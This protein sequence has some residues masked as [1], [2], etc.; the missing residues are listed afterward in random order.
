MKHITRAV[1]VSMLSAAAATVSAQ[2]KLGSATPEDALRP[3]WVFTPS[4]GFSD[5]YD[6]NVT[7]FGRGDADNQ[8][9][10]YIASFTPHGTLTY[11]GKHTR[12]AA[13]Y[14]GSFLNYRTFTPFDRWDQSG[15][16]DLKRQETARFA[17]YAH[18]NGA[19]LPSTEAL[20]FNGIPFSHTG[21]K[22]L[23]ARSGGE[24]RVDARN[25]I[26]SA[27]QYQRVEFDRPGE[28]RQYLRGG[29]ATSWINTFRHKLGSRTD[30][31]ADYVFRRSFVAGDADRSTTH[32][33]EASLDYRMSD[34]WTFSGGA[35]IALLAATP[36]TPREL[37][38][39]MRAAFDRSYRGTTLHA[40][41]TQ[42]VLPSFGLGG[43]VR[44]QEV[45]VGYYTPLFHSRRFYTDH[46]AVFRN[47]TPVIP[48]P[49]HLKLRSFRTSSIV[50][51]APQP[52][53][54]V[55]GFY[56]RTTQSSL[57]PGGRLDRNRVGFRIV[58]S[59]PMRIE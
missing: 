55:E 32:T 37:A 47:N 21:A 22:M 28:L 56:T 48:S 4:F 11:Y 25:A 45:G 38:P 15:Q 50:G 29:R 34:T 40:G 30:I 23:D 18:G 1:I 16:L 42:G 9:N 44:S 27:I 41:Y 8:N 51:W 14:G 2:E 26:T 43:T 13:G 24:F 58:T 19:M 39:A 52:W 10:D 12:F 20:E 6:D 36:V 33:A 3:G 57:I 54:H 31:G 7:L 53:V 49:D 35:G 5:T 17:W 59:K 46:S